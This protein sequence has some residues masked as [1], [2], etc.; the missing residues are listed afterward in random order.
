MN[1][2]I[3]L[4]RQLL[5]NEELMR[6]D[7][8]YKLFTVLLLLVDKITGKW[9]GGR[10]QLARIARIKNSS[11][12]K[13]LLRLQNL[14]IVTLDSNNKYTTVSICNWS[15]YQECSNTS[16]EQ[17]SNNKVTTEEHSNKNKELRIEKGL[18]TNVDKL[19]G[20]EKI[21]S[22]I[23]YWKEVIGATIISSLDRR[24]IWNLLRNKEVKEYFS[25]EDDVE[26]IRKYVDIISEEQD[27]QYFPMMASPKDA[28][29]NFNRF[30]IYMNRKENNHG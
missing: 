22:I 2:W 21:N 6:S 3:K 25:I 5:D 7:N 23:G 17:Q 18:S 26:R 24:Y 15:K 16:V 29:T 27:N 19:H 10:F 4:H 1:G 12:Y 20:N 9:S 11:T 8:A 13:A 14:Q 28:F 30:T